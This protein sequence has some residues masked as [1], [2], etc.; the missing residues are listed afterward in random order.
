MQVLSFEEMIFRLAVAVVLGAI[1][2]FEREL[3]GKRAGVRTSIMVAAGSSIFAMISLV[4]PYVAGVS[5]EAIRNTLPD[6]VLANIVVGVGFLGAGIIVKEG[7]HVRGLTTAATV[8]FVAAIG[9]LAGIGLL[10]FAAV[11]AV[12]LSLLLYFL[13][14]IDLY[15]LLT[16]LGRKEEREEL[17]DEEK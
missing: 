3:V 12:G 2:G 4:V 6:R 9:T 16:R 17:G 15:A 5:E 7:L 1:V 8:W 13:R 14:K 11:S 10:Q